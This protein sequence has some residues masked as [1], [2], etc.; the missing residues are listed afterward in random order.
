[1]QPRSGN[2]GRRA[3]GI[4][5]RMRP[6]LGTVV[7]IRAGGPA[8]VATAGIDAAFARVERVQRLMSFHDPAS[9]VARI[10]AAPAGRTV[11]V[12][13]ETYAVL[14]HALD[15]GQ[16]SDGVFDITVA[17]SLVEAGFLPRPR[18]GGSLPE[19]QCGGAARYIDLEMLL[20]CAVRWRRKG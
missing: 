13:S 14:R 15:L 20:P 19:R 5:A 8:M 6:L 2:S 10:N 4:V 18:T 3:R 17:P 11:V 9:D 12:D 1:M 7:E 16:E